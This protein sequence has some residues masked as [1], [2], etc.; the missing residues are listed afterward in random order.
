MLHFFF[1]IFLIYLFLYW[2]LDFYYFHLFFCG[3]DK[4]DGWWKLIYTTITILGSKRT[5]LGLRDFISL[6]DFYQIIDVTNVS[7]FSLFTPKIHI[8][9]VILCDIYYVILVGAWLPF[10]YIY[11][12]YY[13]S[14]V[15]ISD[16][17]VKFESHCLQ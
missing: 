2:I 16:K 6:G 3:N 1:I 13:L 7:D 12:C 11:C 9:L 5:K 14:I 17:I 10:I 4:V 8:L 15:W